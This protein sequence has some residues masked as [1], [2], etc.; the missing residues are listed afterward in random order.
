[1]GLDAFVRCRCWEDGTTVPFEFGDLLEVADGRVIP[2]VARSKR[3]APMYEAYARWIDACCPHPRMV[4]R[5][6]WIANW[7]GVSEFRRALNEIDASRFP[8]LLREIP[9]LNGG[10]TDPAQAVNCSAELDLF[11]ASPPFGRQILLMDAT[12]GKRMR[13]L[14][15]DGYWFTSAPIRKRLFRKPETRRVGAG[16]RG[17]Y[18]EDGDGNELLCA[19]QVEQIVHGERS[20]ELRDPATGASVIVAAGLSVEEPDPNGNWLE[21][22]PALLA[23]ELAEDTVEEYQDLVERLKSVFR[24]SA[25]TGNPV[26]WF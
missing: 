6:E 11:L 25:D 9:T 22:Y 7:Y 4:F 19:K 10:Q 17:L 26:F 23:V 16:E 24:A 18:V 2:A 5:Q 13:R 12:T 21:R 3:T 14:T 20:I 15:G 1:M 8:N